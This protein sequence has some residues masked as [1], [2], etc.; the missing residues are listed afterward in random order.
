MDATIQSKN[1][2]VYRGMTDS[3]FEL[4]IET[5]ILVPDYVAEVFRIIKCTVVHTVFQ[6][7]MISGKILIEG[8]HKVSVFYQ[9][10]NSSAICQI[11]QKLPFSKNFEYRGEAVGEHRITVT[12]QCEYLN[13]R[14]INQRRIDVRGSYGMTA[15]IKTFDEMPVVGAIE[16]ETIYQKFIDLNYI[17]YNSTVEKQFTMEQ[18]V[19]FFEAPRSILY[20]YS[21]ASINSVEQVGAHIIVKGEVKTSISYISEQDSFIKEVKTIPINQVLDVEVEEGE[22]IVCP[23]I[24]VNSCSIMESEN[25]GYI[26]SLSGGISAAI[27][28]EQNK[29]VVKDAF[30]AES[31]YV[32]SYSNI[33]LLSDREK[34]STDMTLSIPVPILS[35]ISSVVDSFT[36][37]GAIKIQHSETGTQLMGEL[38]VHL[39]CE[40]ELGELYCLDNVGDYRIS[41]I[42]GVNENSFAD[43]NASVTNTI[44][45]LSG[46]DAT[47]EVSI[48]V[49]GIVCKKTACNILQDIELTD[50]V[51]E[52]SSAALCIYFADAGEAVFDIAKRYG[53]SPEGIMTHNSLADEI[54]KAKQRLIVPV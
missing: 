25:E 33:E 53:A 43:I 50:A 52:E 40:N 3:Y 9:A 11:E 17:S 22:L 29:T 37:V 30:S 46:K 7:S 47:V 21:G 41:T 34:I 42:S 32:T 49:Y 28:L 8:Y 51:V 2:P 48:S 14:A 35:E 16:S 6:K 38:T 4:P 54:L 20:N 1:I 24:T 18:E 39:I 27:Y 5:E 44:C 31:N 12:G 26:L 10:E 19:E 15:S 23:C 13:C 36:T 45:N